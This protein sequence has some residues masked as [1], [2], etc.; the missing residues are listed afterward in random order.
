MTAK[1][2]RQAR[3]DTAQDE[4]AT[5]ADAPTRTVWSF[6]SDLSDQLIVPGLIGFTNL[7]YRWRKRSWKPLAARR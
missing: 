3:K 6:L 2:P 1:N 4:Q 5:P 7:G